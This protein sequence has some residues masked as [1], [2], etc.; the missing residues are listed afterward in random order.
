MASTMPLL[1]RFRIPL[2]LVLLISAVIL[3]PLIEQWLPHARTI[4]LSV[5]IFCA[6]LA[7]V[8]RAWIDV[9][10]VGIVLLVIMIS[11]QTLIALSG[12]MAYLGLHLVLLIGP[13]T[14][15]LPRLVWLY[16]YRR[17]LGV[18]VFLLALTH[19]S[20]I[21]STYFSY[22]LTV[23][24][25]YVLPMF[26]LTALLIMAAL[27]I[28]SSDKIQKHFRLWHFE[29]LHLSLLVLYASFL[30]YFFSKI[31]DSL[32]IWQRL[33]LV[34]IL[35]YGLLMSPSAL[36]KRFLRFV[37]GWKQLHLLIYAAYFSVLTHVWMARVS[38][39]DLPK[40]LLFLVLAALVI[41]SHLVGWIVFFVKRY[42]EN[43]KIF[44]STIHEGKKYYH[45]GKMT[46]F[47]EGIGKKIT[48]EKTELA[49]FKHEGKI[50][51]IDN[52][53]PHQGGSL[54]EGRINNGFVECP[55]HQYQFS[56]LD[57]KGPAGYEDSVPFHPVLIENGH[58]FVHVI[59]ESPQGCARRDCCSRRQAQ[60]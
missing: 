2:T 54:S 37:N 52:R 57:G 58:V 41:G 40:R 39:E 5:L 10:L 4:F 31:G 42:K 35:L 59:S 20:L 9:I 7:L 51:A 29:T 13:W 22:D 1:I 34:A 12:L 18:S 8:A 47:Q 26:G 44:E 23:I 55:W 3:V 46:D 56:V 17:H 32:N 16:K 19:A 60:A 49:L 25:T 24:L 38:S 43:K 21:F 53:C 48:I 50:F 30:A 28:T 27:A 11:H 14:R 6:I 15:F 33:I 45:V 36:P